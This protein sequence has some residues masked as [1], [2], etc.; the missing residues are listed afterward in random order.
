MGNL[1]SEMR[2]V[3][4][5]EAE[6]G[7]AKCE[8]R[9]PDVPVIALT[10]SVLRTDLDKCTAAGMDGYIPKPFR[11]SQLIIG[12]AQVLNIPLRAERKIENKTAPTPTPTISSGVTNLEYLTEFCEGDQARMKK[13]IDMFLASAPI[14]LDKNKIAMQNNDYIEIA[15]QMHGYKTKFMMMGMAEAQDLATEIETNCLQENSV[16][17]VKLKM[18]DL[19]RQIAIAVKELSGCIEGRGPSGPQQ[20]HFSASC[21]CYH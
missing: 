18:E 16:E 1:K 6:L 12:I 15:S 9:N 20:Q 3:N 14:L 8:V 17:P 2:N 7:G 21:R 13:Y 11:A 19:V 5:S 4:R 10:A